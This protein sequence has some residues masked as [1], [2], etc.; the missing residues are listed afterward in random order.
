MTL[1]NML[2][3]SA[4]ASVMAVGLPVAGQAQPIS[5]V[6]VGAGAGINNWRD[7]ANRGIHIHDNDIGPVG[8]AA[9]G[10]GFGN[11]MRA[12][13][14]GSYRRH[15]I[16]RLSVN[17]V[18]S[19]RNGDVNR[20]GAMANLLFDFDLSSFGVSPRSYMPYLGIGAGYAWTDI[21]KARFGVGPSQYLIDDTGGAFAYQA[22]VGS[23]IG[24]APSLVPGLALTVE[25]RFFDALQPSIGIARTAGPGAASVPANFKPQGQNHSLLV[26]LRY[27][28]NTPPAAVPLAE[29]P[30][31]PPPP[32]V[33]R[34]YLVFFDWDRA[35]LTDRARQIIAEAAGNARRVAATRIEVAGHADRSGTPAYNQRLSE[36]R[37]QTV[38]AELV[39]QGV[40]RGDIGITAFGES[41]PLVPTA[42]GVREPQ[43]RRVEIILR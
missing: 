11:G 39:R 8:V 41:R 20:Y 18:V 35:E 34:T 2:L 13:I 1:R 30:P 7:N 26:G 10:W 23:A 15:E 37:A 29:A 21:G 25:Y 4:L 24:L 12:E 32:A 31:A 43:N 36:R 27:A 5:G 6:Y 28:F 19:G 42:D 3:A 40:S 17:D 14:E 9:I 38:A 16:E 22:I 33:A